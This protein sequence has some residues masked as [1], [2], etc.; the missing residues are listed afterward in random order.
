MITMHLLIYFIQCDIYKL[1]LV[2][3]CLSFLYGYACAFELCL[4]V[5]RSLAKQLAGLQLTCNLNF[6]LSLSRLLPF[7]SLSLPSSRFPS[8]LLS[9]SLFFLFLFF[10]PSLL[11]LLSLIYLSCQHSIFM[12]QTTQHFPS[13]ISNGEYFSPSNDYV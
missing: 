8:Y 13:L 2:Q 10:S 5:L 4:N 12:S 3:A 9:L 11:L 1:S 6:A 7:L